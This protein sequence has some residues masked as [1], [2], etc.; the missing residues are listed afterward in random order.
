MARPRYQLNANDWFDCLD[1]LDYQLQQPDWLNEP[2]HPVHH[3]GLAVLKECVTQWRDIDR[4]SKD[5]CQSTQSILEE[6]LTMDDWGRMRKSL[7]ARK[8]RRRER[9]RHQK[10]INI[11]LTP[12][13]H[14]ALQE[15]RSLS[16]AATFSEALEQHLTEALSALRADRERQLTEELKEML[17]PFKASRLIHLVET[18]LELAQ[19]RRSLANSCKIAHQLFTKRPDR[20][21]LRLVRDRFIEDLIWNDSH[22]KIPYT[23]LIS[24]TDNQ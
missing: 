12:S 24:L 20:D 1:W 14:E 7:S 21:S 17:A 2:D 4:P 9:R 23:Q 22:L 18:Y 15:F 6:S 8:R 11:T 13:A 5:L 10:S 19:T 16:G 3:F